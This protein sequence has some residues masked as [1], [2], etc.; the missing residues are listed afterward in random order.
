MDKYERGTTQSA[1]LKASYTMEMSRNE[2][3][4]KI[5]MGCILTQ[6]TKMEG[7]S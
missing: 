7:K 2:L 3:P 1:Q 6:M 4:G 5:G